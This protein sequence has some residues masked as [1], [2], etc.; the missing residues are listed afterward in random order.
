[1]IKNVL[2]DIPVDKMHYLDDLFCDMYYEVEHCNPNLHHCVKMKV[3]ELAYDGVLTKNLAEHL[4]EHLESTGEKWPME[5]TS[6]VARQSGIMFNEYSECTF[7]YMMNRM[8]NDYS[9]ILGADVN[10]YIKMVKSFL[11]E[12][13]DHKAFKYALL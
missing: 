1:M 11:S 9:H 8:W 3:Y 5:T 13:A 2:R 6:Q 7:Y 4:V 12:D 10:L